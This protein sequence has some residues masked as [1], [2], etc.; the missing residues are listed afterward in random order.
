VATIHPNPCAK[1]KTGLTKP[2]QEWS[3]SQ[4]QGSLQFWPSNITILIPARMAEGYGSQEIIADTVN[5]EVFRGLS[6]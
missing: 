5:G 1:L 2:G 6:A 4:Q 3:E